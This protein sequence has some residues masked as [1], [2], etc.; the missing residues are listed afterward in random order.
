[1]YQ[2]EYFLHGTKVRTR[3]TT[4]LSHWH[5]WHLGGRQWHQT[6]FTGDQR[7]FVN[8]SMSHTA[9]L[10][11]EVNFKWLNFWVWSLAAGPLLLVVGEKI[12]GCC[13]KVLFDESFIL[14]AALKNYL[15]IKYRKSMIDGAISPVGCDE[16]WRQKG[17]TWSIFEALF[18][19]SVLKEL[20]EIWLRVV[21]SLFTPAC[22]FC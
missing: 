3:D 13:G 15:G 7:A 9:P 18:C 22:P 12:Y 17:N 5:G 6:H 16:L 21:H 19:A 14:G 4:R 10:V 1:M 2:C 8:D 11:S 20:V